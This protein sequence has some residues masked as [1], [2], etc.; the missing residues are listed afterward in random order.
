MPPLWIVTT[1]VGS[2]LQTARNAMQRSLIGSL[3]AI[4]ATQVRFLY[5][6]PFALI[7]LILVSFTTGSITPTLNPSFIAF[8]LTG[9]LCQIAA[10]ALMLWAMQA[11]SFSVTI[12]YTKTEPVQV[13]LFGAVVLG[14]PLSFHAS[15]AILVATL[16]VI[17]MVL[18]PKEKLSASG[19][20]PAL[21]GLAAGGFFALSSV[22][23]RGAIV[24]L[25]DGPFLLR[26][27]TALT[28]SL[29]MQS[30]ILVIYMAAFNRQALTGSITVWKSSL[31]AGLMG[32]AASQLW[33]I[34]FALTSAANVRTLGLVEMIYAQIATHGIF[35]EKTTRREW[36]GM[37]LILIGV[38]ALV[39][40]G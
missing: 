29:G 38:G 23:F 8:A 25:G 24:A 7:F 4:G 6:F 28:V 33:F 16:G 15:W 2:G 36:V 32:S 18:N 21:A 22:F 37:A 31:F 26:A 35:N 12:A 17:I 40:L 27:S 13:A 1:L 3:G 10:T 30:V 34:G 19:L 20:K 11:R 5:G 14:D 9:A 39:A